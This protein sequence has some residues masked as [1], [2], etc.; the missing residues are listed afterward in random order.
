[1]RLE[2]HRS[3]LLIVDMQHDALQRVRVR[4]R[5]IEACARL[6]EAAKRLHVPITLSEHDPESLGLV[7]LRLSCV[8]GGAATIIRKMHYSCLRDGTL[9]A[10]LETQRRFGCSQVVVAGIESHVGVCQTVMDL[11]ARRFDAF[12]VAGAIASRSERSHA[13]AVERMRQ[14]GAEIVD[15]E[16]VLHEWLD[17]A[18]AEASK[19]LRKLNE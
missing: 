11:R 16:M 2:R 18:G 8:A 17:R 3:Q 14:C 7:T 5:T 13:L 4:E 15:F 9:G 12:V 1:M 6:I 10:Y 19:E